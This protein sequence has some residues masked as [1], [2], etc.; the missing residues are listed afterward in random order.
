M[1]I[2]DRALAERLCAAL[3]ARGFTPM[4]WWTSF[5]PGQY[6][7]HRILEL[8]RMVDGAVFIFGNDDKSWYRSD[9]V[10][11]PR[12]NV[13]LE[14]GV[15]TAVL[16]PKKCIIVREQE[17]KMPTDLDGLGRQEFQST[18]EETAT[19]VVEHLESEFQKIHAP[20][21]P[22]TLNL[23]VDPELSMKQLDEPFPK[24]W[25]LRSCYVGLEGAK[26]W[27]AFSRDHEYRRLSGAV[28]VR[29]SIL[30]VINRT[31]LDFRTFV[32]LGPGDGDLDLDI[33]TALIKTEPTLQYIPVDIS[34]GLLL[35]VCEHLGSHVTIPIGILCD[36]EDRANFVT[37]HV[38]GYGR[39]PK[40]YGLLG[41]TFG[42]L[43]TNEHRFL[44]SLLAGLAKDD[45]LLMDVGI[46]KENSNEVPKKPDV[47][48]ISHGR[49]F[50]YSHGAAQVLEI[51]SKEI[52]DNFSKFVQ[53]KIEPGPSDVS[54]TN[55]VI[56]QPV[57]GDGK[58]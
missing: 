40:L 29:K 52:F 8:C 1:C 57:R 33:I 28:D 6:T 11:V 12:D 50:F 58:G 31:N 48:T 4:P 3:A 19:K 20:L 41:G 49:K 18:D 10:T 32:S 45:C 46:N 27:L 24:D 21:R 54:G 38:N 15:F 16:D 5:S 36:F 14:Y 44:G 25:M 51:P 7:Y 30:N 23:L 56:F 34:D 17:S 43:D 13:I 9:A 26:A 55:V 37:F 53:T 39:S 42:N 22:Q 2:R 35:G 47:N